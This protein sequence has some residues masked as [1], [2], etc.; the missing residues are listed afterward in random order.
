MKRRTWVVRSGR[1]I[2]KIL[3]TAFLFF[4]LASSQFTLSF[5]FFCA[6]CALE[7]LHG[8]AEEVKILSNYPPT[9]PLTGQLLASAPH[10]HADQ[11][12]CPSL[13]HLMYF[14]A[15]LFAE[16][17]GR[18]KVVYVTASEYIFLPTSRNQILLFPV[19]VYLLYWVSKDNRTI[20]CPSHI[21]YTLLLC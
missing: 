19:L 3:A 16:R 20:V 1:G 10:T 9:L 18:E 15:H 8:N 21:V 17:K 4:P 12:A 2:S 14:Y 7:F 6:N 13:S 5:F 11:T